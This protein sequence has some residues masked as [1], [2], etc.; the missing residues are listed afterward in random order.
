LADGKYKKNDNS[1]LE[2]K[3]DALVKT[4]VHLIVASGGLVSANAA[5]QA[6]PDSLP[7]L[8]CIGRLP[9]DQE[10]PIQER[11]N[12]AGLS[13][14]S[15]NLNAMREELLNA[16]TD[17]TCLIY[18]INSK[19]GAKERNQ[20]EDGHQNARYQEFGA[21]G[22]NDPTKIAPTITIAKS[23]GAEA[24]IISGDPF[25]SSQADTVV[26]AVQDARI[27]VCYPFK[28]YVTKHPGSIG[29][30]HDLE[31]AYELLGYF[32]YLILAAGASP[33]DSIGILTMRPEKKF[34]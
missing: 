23:N 5:K 30:G 7:I 19:M 27:P 31:Q 26:A 32:T 1:V 9:R 15:P 17:K 2:Q 34:S 3:A 8:V 16:G 24:L 18:N 14:N 29:Y 10:D 12:I 11:K 33:R 21:D 28:S 13:L 4:S 25:F 6:A 20:W 22:K